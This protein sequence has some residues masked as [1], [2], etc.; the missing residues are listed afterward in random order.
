[1][2]KLNSDMEKKEKSQ[3][4]LPSFFR[5]LL[6]SYNFK[7][8]DIFKDEKI[9]IAKTINYGDLSHWKWLIDCYGKKKIRDVLEQIP[10][11]EIRP[12][13]ER[14]AA[15]IFGI[16]RFNHVPRSVGPQE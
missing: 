15:V 4:R 7:N 14:L 11:T 9:I 6:W 8:I 5:P 2:L 10:V 12:R 3:S 1:M 16:R 13:A